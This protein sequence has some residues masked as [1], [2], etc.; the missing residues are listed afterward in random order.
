MK[1]CFALILSFIMLLGLCACGMAETPEEN[2]AAFRAGFGRERVMP[3]SNM[4]PVLAGGDASSRQVEGMLDYLYVTC[5]AVQDEEGETALIYTM[6]SIS[7]A[8]SIFDPIREKIADATGV[9]QENIMLS[10]THTHAAISLTYKWE[11]LDAYKALFTNGMINAA[12]TA[13]ADLSPSDIF[14]G[15][16]QAED[17]VFVRHYLLT[18]GTVTSSG[19]SAASPMI[20][21]HPAEKDAEVQII[22]FQRPQEDKKDILMVSFNSHPTFTEGGVLISA[23]F[24]GPTRDHIESQGDYLVAYYTGD[25]G[26]QEEYSKINE[27]NHG[28]TDYREFGKKL[29]QYVLDAIPSLKQIE[30][31]GVK[32]LGQK[33][34]APAN[35]E[36]LDMLSQA[37]EVIALKNAQGTEAANALA[38]EYGL[39][40]YLE[41]SAIISRANTDETLPLD[42]HVL[43]IGDQLSFVFAPYEMFSENG[44]HIRADTPYDMTFL[45]SC[46]NGA[47]GYLPSATAVEYGCYEKYVTNYAYG[48]AEVFADEFLSML[49]QLK[50]GAQ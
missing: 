5:I 34:N 49:Q 28:L 31:G 12:T 48:S 30:T 14:I 46:A 37:K 19:V 6:D 24:P 47:Q 39:Y 50:N 2:K 42:M 1:R 22:R 26:N 17:L 32:H 44:S 36:R 45:V 20:V 10:A 23:D 13:I 4:K 38:K 41:A 25:A 35:K 21:G 9:K 40:Q 27:E 16:T 29:G 43:A 7:S 8:T 11:G 15:S 18:D 33:Y 3:E